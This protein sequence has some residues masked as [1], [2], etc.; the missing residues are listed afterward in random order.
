[1]LTIYF[2]AGYRARPTYPLDNTPNDGIAD[3]VIDDPLGCEFGSMRAAQILGSHPV[4][5][6]RQQISF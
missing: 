5:Y 3:G 4:P 2:Q 1:M 6:S